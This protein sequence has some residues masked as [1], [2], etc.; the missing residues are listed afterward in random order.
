MLDTVKIVLNQKGAT[1]EDGDCRG[2]FVGIAKV[3]E[4]KN[5]RE[6]NYM[7]I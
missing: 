2:E 5:D 3:E 6:G 7:K 4:L 1:A